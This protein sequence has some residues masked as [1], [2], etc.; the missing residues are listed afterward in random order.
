[1]FRLCAASLPIMQFG[2][3]L[4]VGLQLMCPGGED[5]RLLSIAMALE[6]VLG[7]GRAPDLT[8]LRA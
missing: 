2:A 4:P 1:V 6:T 5:A 3:S 8:G 7:A